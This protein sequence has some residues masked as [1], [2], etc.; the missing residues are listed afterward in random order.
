MLICLKENQ[1]NNSSNGSYVH[2]IIKIRY[3]LRFFGKKKV[4]LEIKEISADTNQMR[5]LWLGKQSQFGGMQKGHC[6]DF[7]NV[8]N[9]SIEQETI[10][11]KLR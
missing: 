4:S 7:R 2:Q 8:E 10:D 11:L 5:A 6:C 3:F 1:S 9:I